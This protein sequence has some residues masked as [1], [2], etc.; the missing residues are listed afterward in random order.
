MPYTFCDGIKTMTIVLTGIL[1]I[2]SVSGCRGKR[3]IDVVAAKEVS[4]SF[5]ADLIAHR[6]DAVLDKM[7]P[8]FIQEINRSEFA[9]HLEN[10][11]QYCGWPLDRELKQVGSGI[12]IYADGHTNPTRKF[13]YAVKTDQYPKSGCYF[14]ID[15]A[16]SGNSL[17]VTTFGPLK[18]T[19]GN[20]FP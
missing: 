4:D 10:L 17:K 9:S 13:T 8:E 15:V 1:L 7:E 16:P 18:V 2:A 6:T 12:K 11:L 20:P 19:S 5:M 14:S 3:S